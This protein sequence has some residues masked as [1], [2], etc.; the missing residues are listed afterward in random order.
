MSP[1][2]KG[3]GSGLNSLESN[4]C[5]SIG[6]G[7]QIRLGIDPWVQGIEGRIPRV[8]PRFEHCISWPVSSLGIDNGRWNEDLIRE[9]FV[10]N[11]AESIVKLLHP[12]SDIEDQLHWCPSR[13]GKFSVKSCY[14]HISD[15]L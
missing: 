14:C 7:C 2:W 13:T 5:W 11:D 15:N 9:V 4:V 6:N 10:P 12:S 3:L 8:N 1:T